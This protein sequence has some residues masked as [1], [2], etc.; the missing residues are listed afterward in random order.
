[1]TDSQVSQNICL[2]VGR[3]VWS[4]RYLRVSTFIY[5][6]SFF[7]SMA[8]IQFVPR[9][10]RFLPYIYHTGWCQGFHC[11]E[12]V[13]IFEKS[14]DDFPPFFSTDFFWSSDS[15]DRI[16]EE[17][18]FQITRKILEFCFFETGNSDPGASRISLVLPHTRIHIT[19][20]IAGF[21]LNKFRKSYIRYLG[22]RK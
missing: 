11:H 13:H 2:N 21:S 5:Q 4:T 7:R 16:L 18:V 14:G 12:T 1:M 19:L 3:L 17:C 20:Q 6:I 8:G 10:C 22:S 9:W 15:F